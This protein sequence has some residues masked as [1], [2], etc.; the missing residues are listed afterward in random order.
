MSNGPLKRFK[1]EFDKLDHNKITT[2]A[3]FRA[4]P[5]VFILAITTEKTIVKYGRRI[6]RRRRIVVLHARIKPIQ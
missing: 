3:L 5:D 6:R 1:F 4:T 2:Q